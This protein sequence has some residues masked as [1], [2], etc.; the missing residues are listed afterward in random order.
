[1]KKL[2]ALVLAACLL[3]GIASALAEGEEKTT[4]TLWCIATE[5]DSNRVAYEKAIPEIEEAFN[6]K[7]EWEAFENDSYKTKIKS[8]S[9]EELP[10]IFFT[11]AG[12]FCGDFATAGK[13]YCLDDAYAEYADALPDVMTK[14]ATYGGK[15]YAVPLTMNI[16]AMF[17]NMDLLK[18]VGYD[19]V[20]ETYEDLI[21]CCDALVEKGIIPFGCSGNATWCVTEYLEPVILKTIGYEALGKIFAGEGTWNDPAIATAVDTFQSMITKGYFD[22]DGLT[23]DNDQVKAKFIAGELAFYQNG[24]WNCGD[25]AKAGDNFKVALWPVMDGEKSTYMQVIGGPAD[26]LA[27]SANGKNPEL[28]AKVAFAL[29]KKICQYSFIDAGS[30]LPAWTPDYDTSL[31]LLTAWCCS[32]TPR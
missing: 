31:L 18:E 13:V 2:V 14:N 22:P 6:V 12:A 16:V 4:L 17:A 3:L 11:W 23:M 30:G 5:S 27:V 7:I 29:G 21:A 26:S 20:P 10:D 32:A 24:T 15:R 25:I 19:K 1:M 28:A 9:A 8:T